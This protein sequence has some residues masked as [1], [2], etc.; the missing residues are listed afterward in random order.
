MNTIIDWL[1]SSGGTIDASAMGLTEF[2]GQGVGA[3]ALRDIPVSIEEMA[4]V[5]H[6]DNQFV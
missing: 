2:E 3:V 6:I 1:T 5:L 4:H